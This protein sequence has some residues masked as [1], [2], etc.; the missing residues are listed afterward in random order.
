MPTGVVDIFMLVDK[1]K[2]GRIKCPYSVTTKPLNSFLIMFNLL[3]FQPHSIVNAVQ[4]LYKFDNDWQ[5]SVVSGTDGKLYGNLD[6][7]TYEVAIFRPNGN[8]TEDIS[9]WNTKQQV[10]AMM[11]VLSQI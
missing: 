10:S 3:N 2:G 8:M 6:D 11:W 7:N 5:I 4:A 1:L 9:G